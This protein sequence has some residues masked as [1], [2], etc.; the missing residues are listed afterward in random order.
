VNPGRNAAMS[1][2]GFDAD[3]LGEAADMNVAGHGDFLR[4]SEYQ[5]ERGAGFVA[6]VDSEVE[7]AEAYVTSL[8][9]SLR[10]PFGIRAADQ[11]R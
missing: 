5:V 1:V 9:T 8:P 3:N 11:Q 7:A 4:K 10:F 2:E 6:R